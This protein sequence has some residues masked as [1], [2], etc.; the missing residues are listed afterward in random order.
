MDTILK[1][2][3]SDS[4]G[5]VLRVLTCFAAAAFGMLGIGTKTRKDYGSLT[6]NGWI[7]L[8]GIVVAAILSVGTSVYEFIT[9]QEKAKAA[10]AQSERL[11]L[12]VRRGIYPLKGITASFDIYF[13]QDIAG[14][15]E[16][17]KSVRKEISEAPNCATARDFRC[18]G[19]SDGKPYSYVIPS[20]SPPSRKVTRSSELFSRI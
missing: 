12:S 15:A 3:T 17:K 1:F 5:F 7:A 19:Q 6:L 9:S 11:I 10:Q 4:F 2:F 14:L 8:V 20:T 13:D 16:Y 18:Y